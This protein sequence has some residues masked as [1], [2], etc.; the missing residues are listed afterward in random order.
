MPE[1]LALVDQRLA[2]RQ[3]LC[4]ASRRE[5]RHSHIAAVERAHGDAEDCVVHR[6]LLAALRREGAKHTVLHSGGGVLHLSGR[7][8]AD[9]A[10]LLRLAR[11]WCILHF[12]HSH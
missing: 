3:Q 11:I 10:K 6:L 12:S 1:H 7:G 4:A 8:R 5:L 9:V 2:L